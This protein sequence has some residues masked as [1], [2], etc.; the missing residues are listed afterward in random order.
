MYNKEWKKKI[1]LYKFHSVEWW[2]VTNEVKDEVTDE[3]DKVTD[4]V[5]GYRRGYRVTFSKILCAPDKKTFS[6]K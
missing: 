6:F 5:W 3:F 2:K 1:T 4:E